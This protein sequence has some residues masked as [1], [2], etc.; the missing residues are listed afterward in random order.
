M[1]AQWPPRAL[2]NCNGKDGRGVAVGVIHETRVT[3]GG[4]VGQGGQHGTLQVGSA[5]RARFATVRPMYIR[6]A[7][8]RQH[9]HVCKYAGLARGCELDSAPAKEWERSRPLLI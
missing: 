9:L 4:S 8:T 7:S 6:L 2:A 3:A 1:I 5:A